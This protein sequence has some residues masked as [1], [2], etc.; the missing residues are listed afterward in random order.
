VFKSDKAFAADVR[1]LKAAVRHGACTMS[2][3]RPINPKK[4]LTASRRSHEGLSIRDT[5]AI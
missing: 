1:A 5:R 2:D 3:G 4:S